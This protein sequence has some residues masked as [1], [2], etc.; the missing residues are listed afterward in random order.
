MS[1]SILVRSNGL[2]VQLDWKVLLPKKTTL[3]II[4]GV[5]LVIKKLSVPGRVYI[6]NRLLLL[7]SLQIF[8][9]VKSFL[10]KINPSVICQTSDL[11][12]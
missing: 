7:K 2:I 9:S 1:R 8:P 3:D 12:A 4:Q 10:K 11:R 6:Q 5:S